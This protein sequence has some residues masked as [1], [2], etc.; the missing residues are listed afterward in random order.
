M[1]LQPVCDVRLRSLV[2]ERTR[3]HYKDPYGQEP[4]DSHFAPCEVRLAKEK[5]HLLTI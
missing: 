1:Y 5:H 2:S 4:C 3:E